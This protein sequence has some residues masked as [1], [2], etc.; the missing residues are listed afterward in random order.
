M[1][2]VSEKV[3]NKTYSIYL[4]MITYDCGS[5]YSV[6]FLFEDVFKTL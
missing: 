2:H 5:K 3:E 6:L 1:I 4:E